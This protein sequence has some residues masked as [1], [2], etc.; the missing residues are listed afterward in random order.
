MARSLRTRFFSVPARLV[1]RSGRP[2]FSAPLEW[3]WAGAFGRALAFFEP[4]GLS[5]CRSTFAAGA[6]QTI[7][8]RR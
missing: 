5:L 7:A 3:R 2:T 4:C 6:P 1:S 8:G